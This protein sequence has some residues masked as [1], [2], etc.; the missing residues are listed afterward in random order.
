MEGDG[1]EVPQPRAGNWCQNQP[2]RARAPSGFLPHRKQVR[3]LSRWQ[4]HWKL[5]V[6]VAPEFN[7]ILRSRNHVTRDGDTTGREQSRPPLGK[8]ARN[9]AGVKLSTVTDPVFPLM[10]LL[11]FLHCFCWSSE[12]K[13]S[14]HFWKNSYRRKSKSGKT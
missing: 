7:C 8:L 5:M 1:A 14:Q 10:L 9:K 12:K 6:R 4:S 3:I 13:K 2:G 11:L